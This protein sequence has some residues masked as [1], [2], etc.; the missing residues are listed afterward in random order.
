MKINKILLLCLLPLMSEVLIACCKCDEAPYGYRFN[1]MFVYNLDNSGKNAMETSATETGKASYGIGIRFTTLMA[2]VPASNTSLFLSSSQASECC[3]P[4]SPHEH[5]GSF[6]IIS[7]YDFN[8]NHK[9]GSDVTEYFAAFYSNRYYANSSILETELFQND[10]D[11]QKN[12]VIDML[13]M[14]KPSAA[15]QQFRVEIKL[16]GGR[17]LKE[18]TPLINLI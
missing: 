9:S 4:F 15:K 17:E 1:Q 5:I 12:I 13:L 11:E 18:T 6:K 2:A 3:R 16:D 14:I 7:I 8:E 10:L